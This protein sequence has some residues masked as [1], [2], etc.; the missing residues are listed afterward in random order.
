MKTRTDELI[1]Q[2]CS[3]LVQFKRANPEREDTAT[4][5]YFVS[6]LAG[7]LTAIELQDIEIAA[8]KRQAMN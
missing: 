2:I 3:G 4:T 5:A 7:I 1:E 8:L 6:L